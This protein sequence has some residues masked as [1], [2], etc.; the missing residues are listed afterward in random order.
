MVPTLFQIKIVEMR[1]EKQRRERVKTIPH[2]WRLAIIS[3][4]YPRKN[5]CSSTPV[6]SSVESS[7][8]SAIRGDPSYLVRCVF[9]SLKCISLLP[10]TNI[11][12]CSTHVRANRSTA[13]L[14]ARPSDRY[15]ALIEEHKVCPF[16]CFSSASHVL[17]HHSWHRHFITYA[18][19]SIYSPSQNK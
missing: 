6:R 4:V 14:L 13:Y 3:E 10:S 18:Y 15:L 2:T 7:V 19:A 1:V 16:V 9:L 12:N 5:D 17:R 8:H 11:T